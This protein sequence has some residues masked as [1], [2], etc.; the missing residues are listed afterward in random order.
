MNVPIKERQRAQ[1]Q[2]AI[3]QLMG[4]GRPLTDS[5]NE[6]LAQH[7]RTAYGTLVR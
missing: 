7:F 1:A 5:E 4:L 6:Q 3:R 2:R